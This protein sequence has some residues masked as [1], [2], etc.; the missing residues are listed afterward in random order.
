M[1]KKE[2]DAFLNLK[3]QLQLIG[4][5]KH[6]NAINA[7]FSKLNAQVLPDTIQANVHLDI[8]LNAIHQMAAITAEI[9]A[10]LFVDI[11][12]SLKTKYKKEKRRC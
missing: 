8:N 10:P 5:S 11:Y 4:F 3:P 2:L 9:I 6:R 1:R 7:F 12:I